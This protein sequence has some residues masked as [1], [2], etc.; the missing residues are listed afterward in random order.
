MHGYEV[1]LYHSPEDDYYVAEIVE[2]IGCATDGPT[3]EEALTN[4]RAAKAAWI[5]GMR[6]MGH[7]IPPPRHRG[8]NGYAPASATDTLAAVS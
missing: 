3:A 6:R 4:L 7:P 2:F 8:R 1:N 5:E